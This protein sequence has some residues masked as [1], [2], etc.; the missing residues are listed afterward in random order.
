MNSDVA[1]VLSYIHRVNDVPTLPHQTLGTVLV[2]VLL[3][4]L[5]LLLL[6]LHSRNTASLPWRALY[7]II[8]I[9]CNELCEY[10]VAALKLS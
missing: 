9:V 1:T 3:L 8:E 5:K 2:K 7:S 10:T 4:L 6:S